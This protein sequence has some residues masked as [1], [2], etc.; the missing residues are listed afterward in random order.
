MLNASPW[1]RRAGLAAAILAA[2]AL[3]AVASLLLRGQALLT[4]SWTS[5]LNRG[6][7]DY[8]ATAGR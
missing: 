8:A 5:W 2:A 6:L 1:L 7:E 4:V 3:G